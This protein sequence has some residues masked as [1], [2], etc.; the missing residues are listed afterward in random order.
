MSKTNDISKPRIEDVEAL[1]GA[2][3]STV[4][5]LRDNELEEVSGGCCNYTCFCPVGRLE[6]R[7]S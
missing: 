2:A 5:E 4:R 7:R 6:W 3:T 1:G